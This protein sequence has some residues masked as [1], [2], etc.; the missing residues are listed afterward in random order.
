MPLVVLISLNA[1]VRSLF[2]QGFDQLHIQQVGM[3]FSAACSVMVCLI[4]LIRMPPTISNHLRLCLPTL[5]CHSDA[6]CISLHNH[7]TRTKLGSMSNFP[8][9][10]PYVL[11]CC[12]FVFFSI[13]HICLMHF[14]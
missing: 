5:Q 9:L 13:C 8:G 6:H 11:G 10:G 2:H 12:L 1:S 14:H 4:C 7:A 3:V